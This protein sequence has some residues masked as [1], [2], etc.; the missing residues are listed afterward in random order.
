M[1]QFKRIIFLVLLTSLFFSCK[2]E[3]KETRPNIVVILCDDLG[4]GDLSAY[5]HPIIQTPNLDELAD[6]GIKFTNFYSAAPVCSPARAGLL[7]GRSPNRAGIYDYI[8][9]AG[10]PMDECLDLVHLQADE[11]TIPAMLKEVGYSTCLAG[12]WHLNSKFNSQE[13]PTPGDFGFDHWFATQNVARPSH[14]NPNNF[15]RKGE[16]VGELKG[17]SCQIV[18]DE[19][20]NWLQNR[21]SENPFYLQ[22][23]IHEPHGPIESPQFLVDDYLP[24]SINVDQAQYFANVANIDDAVGR[25]VQYLKENYGE[26]TLVIF[27]SDNGPETLLR[28]RGAIRDYG[29]P[30]PLKGMKLWTTEGG[31]RVPGILYWLGKETYKGTSDAVVSLLDFMPTFAEISGAK[32]PERALDGQSMIPV[33]ETGKMDRD[34]ALLWIFYDAIN[35]HRVAMRTDNWKILAR[36]KADSTYLPL[37]H[38]LYDGNKDLVK[39]ADL[40]DFELYNM[41]EDIKEA[42]NVAEKYTEQFEEMKKLVKT[43]YS[44]LV[45]GSYVWS[46]GGE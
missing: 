16:E 10:K 21:E 22:I 44:K 12:K 30:G 28:Y 15:V 17:F 11:Q 3:V 4:Y 1:Q 8:R 29:S 19:A 34:K 20:L 43:E 39:Q 38:N 7:T 36:M 6:D 24:K 35:E 18:V 27:S 40:V 13:Q 2:S 46:R 25:L 45:K 31:I 42:E 41:N 9:A 32:L 26:N 23:C 14:K 5:G 33:I 37:I